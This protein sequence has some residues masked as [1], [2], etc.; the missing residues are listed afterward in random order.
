MKELYIIVGI[1]VFCIVIKIYK[2]YHDIKNELE[3]L[4]KKNNQVDNVIVN[5]DDEVNKE[6]EIKKNSLMLNDDNDYEYISESKIDEDQKRIFELMENTNHNLFISGKA[7]TGK[8]FLLKYFKQHTLKRV[9]YTAPTGVAALNIKG[10]TLHKAFGFDCLTTGDLSAMS[11]DKRKVFELMDVL[12]IDEISMVRSDIFD[13]INE[14]LCELMESDEPF[15]GKQIIVIG[16]IFQLPPIYKNGNREIEEII[17]RHG[18]IY[19]FNTKAYIESDFIFE[20]LNKIHRIEESECEFA[21]VLNR[22]RIGQETEKDIELLNRRYCEESPENVINLVP[23]KNKA[24]LI[25]E[26]RL[27]EINL[28]KY[29]YNATI[30]D[31]GRKINENDFPCSF[32]L[33]LKVGALVMMIVNDNEYNRWVNGTMGIVSKLTNRSVY[34]MIN[35]VEYDVSK[36]TFETFKCEYDD[37]EDKIIYQVDQSVTQYPLILAY[38]VTIH[39]SQGMTYKQVIC[40]V[41]GSFATGQAYVALSRC[42]SYDGLYLSKKIEKN[43]IKVSNECIEFYEKNCC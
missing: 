28:E 37:E 42:S 41:D 23:T 7:G 11:N 19:F 9:V 2:N 36:H 33:E 31:G 3:E 14:I 13:N 1:I 40:D 35:G 39:K 20:E 26:K 10:V 22:I 34:V 6:S 21:K 5:N 29:V 12:V 4:K 24:A 43:N 18:G 30:K 38:A 32:K 17:K 25:N 27:N 16:D 15:G 8:S